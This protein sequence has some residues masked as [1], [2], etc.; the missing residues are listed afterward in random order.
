MVLIG[1]AG[2]WTTARS[3]QTVSETND[4]RGNVS[5]AVVRD[6]DVI[7]RM[8]HADEFPEPPPPTA[9]GSRRINRLVKACKMNGPTVAAYYQPVLAF[10]REHLLGD[11]H[12]AVHEVLI[13]SDTD[14]PRLRDGLNVLVEPRAIVGEL[15]VVSVGPPFYAPGTQ[16]A[17][18]RYCLH[19]LHEGAGTTIAV[20][21]SSSMMR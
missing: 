10:A 15:S 11:E 18:T 5:A 8:A 21:R 12:R 17:W 13:I 2:C 6:R 3:S 1:A 20:E 16:W 7:V 14:K 9:G 4:T 19:V